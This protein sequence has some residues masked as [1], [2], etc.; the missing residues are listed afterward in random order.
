M[1]S[2]TY[3]YDAIVIL[4]AELVKKKLG[5]WDFAQYTYTNG[6]KIALLGYLRPIAA[7]QAYIERLAP[8]FLVTGGMEVD[9][10]TGEQ[11]SRARFMAD[12]MINKHRI[13]ANQIIVIGKT[14]KTLGNVQDT[15]EFLKGNRQLEV[16]CLAILS[17]K[18]HLPRAMLF[19]KSNTFFKDNNIKL[20]SLPAESLLLRLA[21]AYKDEIEKLYNSPEMERRIRMEEQGINDFQSGNYR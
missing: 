16:C 18:F 7:K 19:F 14:G 6:S 10:H 9:K 8:K 5:K 15:V 21:P 20:T 13:P 11:I 1:K 4:G 12:I 3:P 17:N 2:I